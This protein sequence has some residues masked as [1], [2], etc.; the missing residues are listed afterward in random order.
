MSENTRQFISRVGNIAK[1]L[2]KNISTQ[3]A[4]PNYIRGLT[5]RF[6]SLLL[7]QNPTLWLERPLN[8]N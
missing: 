6:S 2:V 1:P 7:S 8:E 4:K 3:D 5:I